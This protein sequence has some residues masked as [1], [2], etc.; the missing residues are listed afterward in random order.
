MEHSTQLGQGKWTQIKIIGFNIVVLN[1]MVFGSTFPVPTVLNPIYGL[2]V[3]F[4]CP[5]ALNPIYG[6]WVRFLFPNC[7]GSHIWSLGPIY[8]LWVQ[9]MVFGSGFPVPLC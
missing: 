5:T 2:W 7:V 8:G 9:F 6:L 1:P 4:P 3:Q